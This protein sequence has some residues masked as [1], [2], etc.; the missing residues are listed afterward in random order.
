MATHDWPGKVDETPHTRI[1]PGF[2]LYVRDL[3]VV[4]GLRRHFVASD[5]EVATQAEVTAQMRSL[6]RNPG[7]VFWIVTALAIGS[8]L[9]AIAASSLVATECKRRALAVLRPLG[10]STIT[11]VGFVTLLILFNAVFGLFLAGLLYAATAD[12]LN[13]LLDNQSGELVCRLL[14]NHYLT[15]LLA[16]LLCSVLAAVSGGWRAARIEAAERLCDV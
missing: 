12:V 4:E 8:A 3:G 13:H 10:F 6:N 15:V 5:V 11:L 2:R 16:A 1:Y 14:P 9:V 7:L